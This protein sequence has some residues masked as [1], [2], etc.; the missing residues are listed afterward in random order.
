MFNAAFMQDMTDYYERVHRPALGA[1]HTKMDFP[2]GCCCPL[3]PP[4]QGTQVPSAGPGR[5]QGWLPL[6]GIIAGCGACSYHVQCYAF[7]A[8]VAFA[9]TH[10]ALGLNLHHDDLLAGTTAPSKEL[11][12][13]RLATGMHDLKH[14]VEHDLLASLAPQK[15]VVS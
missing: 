7:E 10:P 12:E 2:H 11:V 8:L 5:L 9:A 13:D 14:M 4:I 3:A 6:W 1:R 15:A